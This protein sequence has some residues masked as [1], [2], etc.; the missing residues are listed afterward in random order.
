MWLVEND[1][2][3]LEETSARCHEQSK[4]LDLLPSML[5]L[6]NIEELASVRGPTHLAIGVFDGLHVG[7][8]MV[9]SR[10]VHNAEETRVLG[11]S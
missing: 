3:R 10:A 6:Q 8:Q 2:I 5:L 11:F 4:I 7:H 9:I 1:P